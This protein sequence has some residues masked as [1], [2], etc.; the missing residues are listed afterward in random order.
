MAYLVRSVLLL[1]LLILPLGIN[2]R[3]H[4]RITN[5]LDGYPDLTFHCKYKDEDLGLQHLRYGETFEFIFKPRFFGN[6]VYSCTF[7]WPGACRLFDI[8][9]ENRDLNLC[10][11][12]NWNIKQSGPCRVVSSRQTDCYPW[13]KDICA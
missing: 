13:S 5:T 7:Q 11:D 1:W 4:V 6:T 2:G 8:Y 10:T 9:V 12:C 3:T